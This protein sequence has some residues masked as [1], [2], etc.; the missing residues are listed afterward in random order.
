M[1][2]ISKLGDIDFDLSSAQIGVI[3]SLLDFGSR[4]RVSE[5]DKS[6]SSGASFVVSGDFTVSYLVNM[7]KMVVDLFLSEHL[8]YIFDDDSAH[9]AFFIYKI[10]ST[11]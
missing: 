7:L 2:F 9:L 1:F 10:F 8:W 4:I 5:A 3:I 6:K 11:V